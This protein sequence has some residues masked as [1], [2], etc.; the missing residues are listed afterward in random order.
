VEEAL[1]HLPRFELAEVLED[2]EALHNPAG[3]RPEPR[4]LHYPIGARPRTAVLLNGFREGRGIRVLADNWSR[5]LKGYA[6]GVIAGPVGVLRALAL[7]LR[8]GRVKMV[9]LTHAV[10][11]FTGIEHGLLRQQDRDLFWSI[12]QVPVFEQLRGLGGELLAME[13]EAH[14]GLHIRCDEAL[15]EIEVS[16]GGPELI[17]TSMSNLEYP[18]LRLAT[19]L[20]ADVH[21]LE[22][23]CGDVTPRL[24]EIRRLARPQVWALAAAAGAG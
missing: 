16:H 9:P 7:A 12:F 3:P 19:G 15:L 1:A 5:K 8:D 10:I 6:P 18:L 24:T 21:P 2:F 4:K 14:H 20:A 11:A 17:Y 22:C 13:C 23:G